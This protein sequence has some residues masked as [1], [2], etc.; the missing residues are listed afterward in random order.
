[1]PKTIEIGGI[2]KGRIEEVRHNRYYMIMCQPGHRFYDRDMTVK[3]LD[4]NEWD[5]PDSTH[6]RLK[7]GWDVKCKLRCSR[8]GSPRAEL[9][10]YFDPVS[11]LSDF[12]R[13]EANIVFPAC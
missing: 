7:K 9:L 10:E 8:N 12:E 11:R 5:P 4:E 13:K 2:F 6:G 3:S 1:M